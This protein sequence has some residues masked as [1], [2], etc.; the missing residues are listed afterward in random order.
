MFD[1]LFNIFKLS[2]KFIVERG[3][4]FT[5]AKIIL[6]KVKNNKQAIMNLF[7]YLI[8]RQ[9]KLEE[10]NKNL[11]ILADERDNAVN[12]A[13]LAQDEK[14]NLEQNLYAQ[15]VRVINEKKKKIRELD[16]QI[17]KLSK[18]N[19]ILQNA[20]SKQKTK[21]ETLPP[22]TNFETPKKRRSGHSIEPDD[23]LADLLEM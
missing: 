12:L 7:L 4:Q 22:Q 8:L 11:K 1:N 21:R 19:E 18:E 13:R 9:Q 17:C 14:D 5:A 2:I 16:A 3:G 23:L 6:K 10:T 15:F 20:L